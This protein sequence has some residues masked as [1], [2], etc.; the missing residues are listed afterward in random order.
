M[1][2][3]GFASRLTGTPICYYK[4][5]NTIKTIFLGGTVEAYAYGQSIK[6]DA[7][8][9]NKMKMAYNSIVNA[10]E[11]LDAIGG[12]DMQFLMDLAVRG[13]MVREAYEAAEGKHD[14]DTGGNII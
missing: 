12:V 14:K 8:K 13:Q 4:Y 1:G 7:E 11:T 9:I 10:Y 5:M 2:V 3:C 6:G